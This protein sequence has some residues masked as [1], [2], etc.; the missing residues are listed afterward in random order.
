[1][2][3]TKFHSSENFY[4]RG[5]SAAPTP[6]DF[7]AIFLVLCLLRFGIFISSENDRATKR[8]GFTDLQT[9]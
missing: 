3:H 6:P 4:G 2:E 9:Q 1:M 8:L 7:G 5:L